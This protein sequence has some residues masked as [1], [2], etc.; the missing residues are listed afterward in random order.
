MVFVDWVVSAVPCD[1]TATV[2]INVASVVIVRASEPNL[3]HSLLR[4]DITP[5]SSDID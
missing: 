4:V 5:T 1:F 3:N 2:G